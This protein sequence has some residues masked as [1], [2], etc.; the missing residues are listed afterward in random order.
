[1]TTPDTHISHKLATL[2][3]WTSYTTTYYTT[4]ILQ[5][6]LGWSVP[7]WFS[8]ST[9]SRKEPLRISGTGLS[10]HPTN[11]VKA[12]KETQSSDLNQWSGLVLSS[13]T[14]RLLKEEVLLPLRRLSDASTLQTHQIRRVTWYNTECKVTTDCNQPIIW[15]FVFT[16]TTVV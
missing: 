4:A 1:M 16:D 8:S 15:I 6:N 7:T 2:S 14:T 9:S 10:C 3:T 12:L 11:S 13:S 5:T